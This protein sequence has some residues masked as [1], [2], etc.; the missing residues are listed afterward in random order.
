M[1]VVKLTDADAATVI[2]QLA[3]SWAMAACRAATPADATPHWTGNVHR[4]RCV[5]KIAEQAAL[6]QSL[7]CA[8]CAFGI[9][10]PSV[11]AAWFLTPRVNELGYFH[12]SARRDEERDRLVGNI[13]YNFRK[14]C[15]TEM[16]MED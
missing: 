10:I 6:A 4:D 12:N 9:K 15:V 8:L 2:R 14:Y 7:K 13:L 5:E 16:P 1:R 3:E 11:N